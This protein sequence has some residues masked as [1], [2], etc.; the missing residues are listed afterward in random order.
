MTKTALNRLGRAAN[1]AFKTWTQTKLAAHWAL[2]QQAQE[3]WLEA[4][5]EFRAS[6][7]G[8]A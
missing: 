8:E 5:K 4:R 3:T 1:R 6:Q 7:E 2:Y